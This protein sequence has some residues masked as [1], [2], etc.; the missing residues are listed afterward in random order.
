MICPDGCGLDK[1]ELSGY[2]NKCNQTE[3]LAELQRLCDR[4]NILQF[5]AD[6]QTMAIKTA[7]LYANFEQC[8]DVKKMLDDTL[9]QK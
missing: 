9:E 2:E 8:P 1:P 7:L 4:L 3:L 6:A 5:K